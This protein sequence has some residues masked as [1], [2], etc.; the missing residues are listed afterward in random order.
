MVLLNPSY[1]P[2]H[3]I[4]SN[5]IEKYLFQVTRLHILYA[6]IVIGLVCVWWLHTSTYITLGLVHRPGLWNNFI[7]PSRSPWEMFEG[8]PSKKICGYFLLLLFCLL[9]TSVFL[10]ALWLVHNS[11][12]FSGRGS[13][14]LNYFSITKK[15]IKD[16]C[17]VFYEGGQ[18]R[19][20]MVCKK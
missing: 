8:H 5:N 15:C 20:A 4:K 11:V 13:F 17:S 10:K 12:C 16:I 19:Y 18:T 3:K 6:H 9:Q 2:F 1:Y 7:F 14:P